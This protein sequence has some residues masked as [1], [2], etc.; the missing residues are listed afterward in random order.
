MRE[1][2]VVSVVVPFY[3]SQKHIGACIESLLGQQRVGGPVEI[4]LVDNGSPDRSASVVAQYPQVTVLQEAAPGA[5]AARNTAIG[6]ASA[7]VLAFTD[8]DCVAGPLWLRGA[9][10]AMADPTVGIAVGYCSYPRH[11]SPL[12]R[13]L[14]I[15]E[16][17]KAAYV[18]DRLP[19][20]HHFA[21]ANNMAVRATIFERLGPFKAWP[22]AADSELVHRLAGSG[23]GLRLVF[24]PTME[25][26][27][28]E[29]LRVRDRLRRLALYGRTNT[30]IGTFSELGLV[31][32]LSMLAYGVTRRGGRV[33]R[34]VAE[35]GV[36]R[37]PGEVGEPRV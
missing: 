3:R 8:A 32:R 26:T 25:V 24:Q 6:A 15:Y 18:I 12:L 35:N 34:G 29:F 14:G 17:A 4:L 5:Y 7:D 19:S 22:R 31:E 27:H 2:P 13:L 28:M 23:L 36:L 11:S 16:N 20:S 9:L 33:S 1:R 21:Y 10:D 37:Q 30:Q